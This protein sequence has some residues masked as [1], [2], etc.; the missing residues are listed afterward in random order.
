[1]TFYGYPILFSLCKYA[2]T[3]QVEGPLNKY[4]QFKPIIPLTCVAVVAVMR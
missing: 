2:T 1:M 4:R 3:G